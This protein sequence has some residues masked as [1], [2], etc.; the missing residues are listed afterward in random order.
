MGYSQYSLGSTV[1]CYVDLILRMERVG[2][3]RL[4]NQVKI[5]IAEVGEQDNGLQISMFGRFMISGGSWLSSRGEHFF[6]FS[7]GDR[8]APPF[9]NNNYPYSQSYAPPQCDE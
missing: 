9:C 1:C 7:P 5:M 4:I 2:A 6:E 3:I 8:I